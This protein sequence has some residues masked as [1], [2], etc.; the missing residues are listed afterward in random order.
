MR[1]DRVAVGVDAGG[2]G[3]VV[4]GDVNDDRTL[5][6]VESANPNAVGLDRAAATI[7]GAIV[8]W[9][10]LDGPRHPGSIVVGA[11][12]AGRDDV[13]AAIRH[14]IE[15]TFPAA[16]VLVVDDARI[17][18]RA[19]VPQGDGIVLVA[20]TGSIA[21]GEFGGSPYRAGGYGYLL[22][23]EGSGYAI[24]TAA[25]RL[26]L[27]SFEGR[28]PSDPLLET[29]AVDLRAGNA[30][31]VIRAV[32]DNESP[33]ARVARLAGIVIAHAD[34]GE[35]SATKLVQ[36]AAQE[37]FELVRYVWRMA[38]PGEREIPLGL[39]GGLL[40]ENSMLKFLLET[41][42]ANELPHA[43]IERG[44]IVPVTGAVRLARELLEAP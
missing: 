38:N 44:A 11:A 40:T 43:R 19:A 25:V 37:L 14:A 29:L 33:V 30:T 4:D 22:G 27:R 32:Y 9:L 21:Y 3:V 39:T 42:I 23:D 15:Q 34:L 1:S 7:V 36:T 10:Q 31:D 5:V 16:R 12:G 17:A 41:R 20:G 6:V 28:V 18:L 26:L 8:S 24:G 35:R 2:S 13:A